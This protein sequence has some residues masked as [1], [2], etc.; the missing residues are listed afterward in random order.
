MKKRRRLVATSLCA[1]LALFHAGEGSSQNAPRPLEDYLHTIGLGASDLET[2]ENGRPVVKLFSTANDND[3]AVF[4][5]IGVRASQESVLVHILDLD[6]LLAVKGRRFRIFSD[7]AVPADVGE[8]AFSES[9]YRDL[10]D[11]SLIHI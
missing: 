11:L 4:G 2:A 9:D 5:M 6:Q 8:V 7:P 3:L 10:R 1:L